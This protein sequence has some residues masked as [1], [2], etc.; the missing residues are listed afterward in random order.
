MTAYIVGIDL[1]HDIEQQLISIVKS[2]GHEYPPF[3]F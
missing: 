2:L 3:R 1:V